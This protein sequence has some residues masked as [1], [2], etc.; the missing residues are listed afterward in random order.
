MFRKSKAFQD[1]LCNTAAQDQKTITITTF[2]SL[3]Q[4]QKEF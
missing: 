2:G 4:F 3:T 1:G